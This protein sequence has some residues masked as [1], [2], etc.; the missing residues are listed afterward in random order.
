M[1]R[2]FVNKEEAQQRLDI[3]K[4]C[5]DFESFLKMCK[6][7]NCIMPIKTT[8]SRVKCPKDKW[9]M[10]ESVELKSPSDE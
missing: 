2:F 1:A 7:C 6:I 4:S 8:L 9:H 3:C 5:Q 10:S